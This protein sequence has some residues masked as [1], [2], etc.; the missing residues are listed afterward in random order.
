MAAAKTALMQ[1]F[2]GDTM[3][4]S[5]VSKRKRSETKEIVGI[6]RTLGFESRQE[7]DTKKLLIKRSFPIGEPGGIRTHDPLIKS[8]MLYRL[9]YG[10]T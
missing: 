5:F 2:Q 7:K 10:P 3:R 8:Q 9:S 1:F 6:E 4:L